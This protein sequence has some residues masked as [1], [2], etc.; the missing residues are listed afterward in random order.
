VR[1][2]GDE[3]LIFTQSVATY[4]PPS[5]SSQKKKKKNT[6]LLVDIFNPM[7]YVGPCVIS[8]FYPSLSSLFSSLLVS[9]PYYTTTPLCQIL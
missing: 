7:G 2:I 3:I 4:Q 8:P 6:C 9:C 1:E 5:Y